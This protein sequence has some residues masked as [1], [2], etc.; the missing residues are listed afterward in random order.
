MKSIF[1]NLIFSI[2]ASVLFLLPANSVNALEGLARFDNRKETTVFLQVAATPEE[3]T[4]GLMNVTNL[5]SNRGMVFVFR[6]AT[7]VTFWMKD[8]LISLD[9]I[10]VNNGEIVK[11]AKNT[12][13]NQ[14]STL[15]PSDKAV[16]EV[17]EVNGGFSDA[18]GINIGDKVEFENIAQIDY[19]KKS[20]LMIIKK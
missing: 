13:P 1:R 12:V 16:T 17:I 8:T 7:T 5:P 15:Y 6:P 18:H 10:F 9:M 14:T 19:S 4:K 3:K 20:S 11:I 2:L